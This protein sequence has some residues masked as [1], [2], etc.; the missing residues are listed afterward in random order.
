[1]LTKYTFLGFSRDLEPPHIMSDAEPMFVEAGQPTQIQ[2]LLSGHPPPVVEWFLNDE[3]VDDLPDAE[4]AYQDGN[5][6]LMIRSTL[7]CH[8]GYIMI[9]AR[10]IAGEAT[11][12]KELVVV[13]K[14]PSIFDEYHQVTL[15]VFYDSHEA[16]F[17]EWRF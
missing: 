13:G 9:R 6:L 14:D 2:C 17:I 11:L 12:Y 10:N 3:N 4:R 8:D 16:F 5:H 1:M 7:S 15:Q